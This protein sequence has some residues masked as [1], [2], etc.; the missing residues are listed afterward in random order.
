MADIARVP[1]L[2]RSKY[3]RRLHVLQV[4]L[5]GSKDISGAGRLY[6][7]LRSG[8]RL[9]KKIWVEIKITACQ[10]AL[11]A[12]QSELALRW[13]E[14]VVAGYPGSK[15]LRGQA[16]WLR[17][18][19]RAEGLGG[20]DDINRDLKQ[21]FCERPFKF[22]EIGQEQAWACCPAWLPVPIGSVGDLDKA[23][24]SRVAQKIRGSILDGSF[25][26]CSRVHCPHISSKSLPL[27]R[28]VPPDPA[29]IVSP[30][31]PQLLELS[32]DRSCNLTCPSCRT[33][34]IV[35]GKAEQQRLEE[36]FK[37]SVAPLLDTAK[38]VN[39]TG[40]GDPFGSNHFRW[41]LGVIGQ[42]K[43]PAVDIQTNGVLFDEKAWAACKLDGVVRRVLVSLDAATE[44]TYNIV[45]R[46]GSFPRAVENVRFLSAMRRANKIAHLQLEFVVQY[47][48]FREILQFIELGKQLGVDKVRFN[49]IR[50]WGTF[51]GAG[52]EHHFIGHRKHELNAELIEIIN[53]PAF[54]DPIVDPGNL[55]N[56]TD[57]PAPANIYLDHDVMH[58]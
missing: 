46:G 7:V 26:Y 14:A 6:L 24:N 20:L 18:R 30:P 58:T 29:H 21:R 57:T 31:A 36:F 53:S 38:V 52:F 55:W 5:G 22:M 40:T 49:M 27:R 4:K 51:D 32:Y 25:R 8:W 23:W 44:P 54:S 34:L 47:T 17:S 43:Q 37:H 15:S 3:L 35:A 9:Y 12:G 33:Q 39:I 11:A 41:V 19:D 10:L 28:E 50:N 1:L 45:R 42:R 56:F 16:V 13:S 2:E 48:N